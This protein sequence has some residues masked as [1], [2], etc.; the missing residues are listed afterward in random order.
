MSAHE[1]FRSHRLRLARPFLAIV[2]I[3]QRIGD[4]VV[5]YAESLPTSE[6]PVLRGL[7][8]GSLI[9]TT[10]LLIGAWRRLAWARYVLIAVSSISVVGMIFAAL[11]HWE[12]YTFARL[13]PR[14][15]PLAGAALYLAAMVILIRSRRVRHFADR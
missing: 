1:H 13:D 9:W 12:E 11:A 3:L 5:I 14:S 2:F 10:A 6:N 7:A 8:I 15:F 4:G